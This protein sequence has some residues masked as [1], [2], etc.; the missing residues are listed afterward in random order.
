MAA[1]GVS[2]RDLEVWESTEEELEDAGLTPEEE[3]NDGDDE[4]E[5]SGKESYIFMNETMC[6][7]YQKPEEHLIPER[8][9][10]FLNISYRKK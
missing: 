9:E 5:A 2:E 6:L 3:D 7:T 8:I 4:D 1:Q 10:C